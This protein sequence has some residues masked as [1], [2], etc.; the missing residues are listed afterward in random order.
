SNL[1]IWDSRNRQAQLRANRVSFSHELLGAGRIEV[2]EIL[3]AEPRV[4]R[5]NGLP[6][7]IFG[8]TFPDHFI[9]RSAIDAVGDGAADAGIIERRCVVV[10]RQEDLTVG[11]AY[12]DIQ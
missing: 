12:L 4:S 6:T 8:E 5:W 1:G 10:H 9:Q 11:R 3:I 2:I 7:G